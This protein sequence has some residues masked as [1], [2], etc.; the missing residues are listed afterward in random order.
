VRLAFALVVACLALAG[1]AELRGPASD[2]KLALRSYAILHD[3]PSSRLVGE[4]VNLG[5]S[6]AGVLRATILYVDAQGNPVGLVP[7]AV[8][9]DVIAANETALFDAPAPAG[10]TSANVTLVGASSRVASAERQ[11]LAPRDVRTSQAIG[12]ATVSFQGFAVNE[13]EL[14]V[15]QV[16]A[17]I[18]FRD[19]QGN[20]VGAAR[21]FPESTSLTA[22]ASSPFA[23]S[24]TLAGEFLRYDV[25]V[26][27]TYRA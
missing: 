3:G 26:I 23:G 24:A 17:Q 21:A 4:L 7:A 22:G 1:C 18:A 13:G 11:H 9:R 12:N 6:N 27:T 5:P 10:A 16:E 25:T 19:A 8:W 14:P 2:A 15:P 20:L